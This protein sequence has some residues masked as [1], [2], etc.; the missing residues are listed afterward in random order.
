MHGSNSGVG[1]EPARRVA[2]SLALA[3]LM[4][5][6]TWTHVQ[7]QADGAPSSLPSPLTLEY[8]QRF[9]RAHRAEI[10]AARARARA[11][12]ERKE[13]VSALEDP[14]VSPSLDHLPFM[15]HGA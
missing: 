6:G 15:L 13:V 9:A 3:L 7:A 11:A 8:V 14:T 12:A 5:I 2:L 10:R 1:V 4:A